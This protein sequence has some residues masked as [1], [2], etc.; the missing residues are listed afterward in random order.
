M[1][2][3][4][5]WAV[6]WKLRFAVRPVGAAWHCVI[7]NPVWRCVSENQCERREMRK[8]GRLP[9]FKEKRQHGNTK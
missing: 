3:P 5:R 9:S 4:Q 2:A 1:S 6:P 7:E 8:R